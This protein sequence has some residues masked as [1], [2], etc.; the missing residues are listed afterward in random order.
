MASKRDYYEVLGVAK[1]ADDERDQEGLPQAGHAVPPRP[2]RRRRGGGRAS[3]RKRPRPTR[4]CAIRRSASATTATA[5][6]AWNGMNMPD[7]GDAESVFDMFGDMFGDLF[8][9]RGRRRRRGPQPGPQPRRRARAGPGR[10]VPRR[11][12]NRHHPARG[13]LP[14]LRAARAA[15]RGTQPAD[16]PALQ[17]PGRRHWSTRASSACSRPVAAAAARGV[18]IT[19][20]CTQL[21]RRGPG[22]GSNATT[23]VQVPP[24]VDTGDALRCPGRG[25]GRRARCAARRPVLP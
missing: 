25:R 8:G 4:C 3:S 10:G 19:D 12:E 21:P 17:R 16:L 11:Q 24:G 20:P 6:P 13:D 14:R 22:R 15:S 5:T 23:E 2:Q 1:D 7:F 9:G 18:I